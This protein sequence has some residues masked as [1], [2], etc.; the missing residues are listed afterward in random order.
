MNFQ[1]YLEF[2][3]LQKEIYLHGYEQREHCNFKNGKY[4]MQ[5][6]VIENMVSQLMHKF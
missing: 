5:E 3:S 6:V 1:K 2:T 4:W